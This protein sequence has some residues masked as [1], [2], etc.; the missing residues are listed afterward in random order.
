M[1]IVEFDIVRQLS[2]GVIYREFVSDKANS[3][4]ATEVFNLLKQSVSKN[5]L[6][7]SLEALRTD[8][9]LGPH[10]GFRNSE[11][12]Y[13]ITVRGIGQAESS[14]KSG[15]GPLFEGYNN[16]DI[17]LAA[18]EQRQPSNLNPNNDVWEPLPIER[19]NP[20]YER[21]LESIEAVVDRVE[22]DNGYAASA[23]EER[24]NILWSLRTGLDALKSKF[25]TRTQV[26]ELLVKPLTFLSH[27]FAENAVGELAKR[28]I[29]LILGWLFS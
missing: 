13:R 11:S 24:Q 28:A 22:G 21:V 2:L 12:I 23:P 3:V 17:F 20:T 29:N 26:S 16:L 7:S 6:A 15:K 1:K 9:L 18:H 4:T 14:V 8:E 27:R 19:G 25:P 10:S 5:I